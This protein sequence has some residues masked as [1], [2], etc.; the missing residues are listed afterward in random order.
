MGAHKLTRWQKASALVPMA[1][2]VGAWG[3]A[4]GNSGLANASDGISD[5]EIPDV[6]ATAFEQPASVQQAPGGVDQKA[7][8][9]GT[10]ATL[11]T[12][13]IPTAA[14]AAYRRAETLLG[15]ADEACN[16]PW[17]L[18][19]AIGRVESNHGRTNGNALDTTGIAQPGI[20]GV[21]LDGNDGRA[22][23]R[24]TDSGAL[25][26]NSVYDLAVGPMQFIPGTWASVGV[27]SDNDGSKNP[28][29][30]NDAATSAGI[31]LCAG[32][33][34]LSDPKDAA[35][36]VKRY[37]N[38]DAYVDLVLQISAA[39]ASGDFTQSPNG[40]ST[41]PILTSNSYDQT[42]T[43]EQR[44]KAAKTQKAAEKKAS[45]GTKTD[46]P[47]K[48]GPTT[49]PGGGSTPKPGGSG[50]GDSFD[51][52]STPTATPSP[53]AT[54]KAP[55]LGGGVQ[56]GVKDTP[57]APITKPVTDALSYLEAQTQCLFKVP[58]GLPK[59]KYA[60]CMATYGF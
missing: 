14:L 45:E 21:P 51:E 29:S 13:G 33:G 39:Y 11:S 3:A 54:T 5:S 42:L 46:K 18:V 60:A 25:D 52:P 8:A 2:L 26:K 49:P 19:A 50:G 16:L 17:N 55:T 9:A 57:L 7:G 32:E 27:D 53:T 56:D 31:Y 24:D 4:L 44:S 12:N 48:P 41:S 36:A 23:I 37:N 34:D 22:E 30:I 28:Q 6:P 47:S 43:P 35:V 10:V 1:V 15:K 40:I 38:S 59:E 20:Y 58:F